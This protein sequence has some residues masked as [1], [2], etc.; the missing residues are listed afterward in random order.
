MHALPTC[1]QCLVPPWPQGQL[2]L[3]STCRWSLL[4]ALCPIGRSH[5]CLHCADRWVTRERQ[6]TAYSHRPEGQNQ[7][8]TSHTTCS[9][10]IAD[11]DCGLEMKSLKSHRSVS[12][13]AGI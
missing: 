11:G 12:E 4:Y 6:A 3:A 10:F 9:T 5:H 8:F 7:A 13:R 1:L 2:L